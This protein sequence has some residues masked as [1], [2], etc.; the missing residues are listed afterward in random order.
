MHPV[1][2]DTRTCSVA[3]RRNCLQGLPHSQTLWSGIG[4]GEEEDSFLIFCVLTACV[5]DFFKIIFIFYSVCH[6]NFIVAFR[7]DKI[8]L[9]QLITFFV[10]TCLPV[11]TKWPWKI[12][13]RTKYVLH[14]LTW[15]I[16][17]VMNQYIGEK[18][19]YS[20]WHYIK[21]S[22]FILHSPRLFDAV[23]WKKKAMNSIWVQTVPKLKEFNSCSSLF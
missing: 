12:R 23:T 15:Y 20:P 10:W 8:L 22:Q 7:K 1:H 13:I 6:H 3:N 4:G 9:K 18:W 14:P 11:S 19:A 16:L 2:G 5:A 21:T 17:C